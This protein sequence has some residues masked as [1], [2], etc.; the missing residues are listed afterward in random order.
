MSGAGGSEPLAPDQ[1]SG[2]V[3]FPSRLRFPPLDITPSLCDNGGM[4]KRNGNG[5][6]RL[7]VKIDTRI[8]HDLAKLLRARAEKDDRSQGSVVRR[9]LRHY[10]QETTS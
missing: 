9:A 8:D 5:N 3:G 4:R 6:G 1:V 7:E 10:L 2:A